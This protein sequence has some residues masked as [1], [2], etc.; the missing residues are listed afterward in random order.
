LVIP[1]VVTVAAAAVVLFMI[2]YLLVDFGLISAL[3]LSW[4]LF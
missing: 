2:H 1:V 3:Q 4:P